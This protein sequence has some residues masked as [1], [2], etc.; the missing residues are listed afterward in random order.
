MTRTSQAARASGAATLPGAINPRP[1]LTEYE[2]RRLRAECYLHSKGV[3][4][5]YS[6]PSPRM[7]DWITGLSMLGVFLAFGAAYL[8]AGAVG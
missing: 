1:F 3:D 6:G 2:L 5:Y 8:I 7:I 4:P